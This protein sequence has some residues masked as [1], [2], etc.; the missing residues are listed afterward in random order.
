MNCKTE[1]YLVSIEF[2]YSDAPI[3]DRHT[4][5]NKNITIGIYDD[6]KEACKYG[7][8]LIEKLESRFKLHEFPDGKK[9]N[10]ERFSETGG[11][12]GTKKDLITNLA[13]LRTPFEFYAKI[14]TLRHDAIENTIDSVLEATKRYNAYKLQEN[15]Q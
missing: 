10:R 8:E 2:R 7:N 11:C 5:R 4:S 1:K 14:T 9:A 3:R 12:F 13:F 15:E 6:F